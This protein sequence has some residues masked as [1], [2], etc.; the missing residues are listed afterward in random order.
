MGRLL[1]LCTVADGVETVE[2]L[3]MLREMGCDRAQGAAVG[4]ALAVDEVALWLL[5]DSR[6]QLQQLCT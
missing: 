6:R 4:P 5:G 1:G 3:K 2:Q